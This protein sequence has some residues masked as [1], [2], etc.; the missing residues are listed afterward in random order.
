MVNYM[1]MTKKEKKL[2]E[3][4]RKKYT[5]DP[6][7]GWLNADNDTFAKFAS[8]LSDYPNSGLR[9]ASRR[10]KKNFLLEQNKLNRLGL[11]AKYEYSTTDEDIYI[12]IE[13][14]TNDN[15]KC[16]SCIKGC[17]KKV[18]Y[19]RGENKIKEFK[20]RYN[21]WAYVVDAK[22]KTLIANDTYSCPNC[23]AV[24]KIQD[25]ELGCSYCKS[26]FLLEDIYPVVKNYYTVYCSDPKLPSNNSFKLINVIGFIF[27]IM[28][29]FISSLIEPGNISTIESVF[30][31]LFAGFVGII[32]FQFCFRLSIISLFFGRVGTV[33]KYSPPLSVLSSKRKIKKLLKEYDPNSIYESFEGLIISYLKGIVF[34]DD[35]TKLSYYTG[36]YV[37][38]KTIINIDYLGGIKLKSYDV[39]DNMLTINLIVY[40]LDTIYENNNIYQKVHPY[41]ITLCKDIRIINDS[42]FCIEKVTCNSC[43]GSFDAEQVKECPYCKSEFNLIN[44]DYV[45]SDIK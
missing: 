32:I 5:D 4:K 41:K 42:S 25:L 7:H 31:C 28:L 22:D 13:G 12:D 38:F 19:Y 3:E 18:E 8:S 6:R 44:Y 14:D 37:D 26:H 34:S 45:I 27:G 43:G 24:N 1:S 33:L 16:N 17:E 23:G 36:A 40:M 2:L 35:C 21:L 30:S 29:F 20:D 39:K 9:K 11:S 10:I 15:Y